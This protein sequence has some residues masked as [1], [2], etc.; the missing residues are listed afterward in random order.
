MVQWRPYAEHGLFYT[1]SQKSNQ[2]TT[3][4]RDGVNSERK[5][6]YKTRISS[7]VRLISAIF[8]P[9]KASKLRLQDAQNA[10]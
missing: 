10:G 1:I 9:M 4:S 7:P 8:Q 2:S 5:I 3:Q 6:H